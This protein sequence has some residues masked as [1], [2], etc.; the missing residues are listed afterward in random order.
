[1]RYYNSRA[2]KEESAANRFHIQ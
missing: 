2:Y 1:M